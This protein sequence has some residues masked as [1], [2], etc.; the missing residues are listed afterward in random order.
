MLVD[1][2]LPRSSPPSRTNAHDSQRVGSITLQRCLMTRHASLALALTPSS[3]PG[4]EMW[5]VR[6]RREPRSVQPCGVPDIET[7]LAWD[8]R[9]QVSRCVDCARCRQWTMGGFPT[10]PPLPILAKPPGSGAADTEGGAHPR[11]LQ[12]TGKERW[13]SASDQGISLLSCGGDDGEVAFPTRVSTSARESPLKT[14]VA[15]APLA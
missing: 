4:R 12:R 9:S 13:P 14:P 7:Q 8:R 15:S 11:F 6:S 1:S 10:R 2:Q 5:Q 3:L